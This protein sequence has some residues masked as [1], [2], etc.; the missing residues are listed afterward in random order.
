MTAQEEEVQGALSEG[1]E[2]LDLYTPVRIEKKPDGSV[3]ALWVSRNMVGKVSFERA[4]DVSIGA[5]DERVECD[6]IVVAV[7]Q[8]IETF[9]M[10][11]EG[12]PIQRGVIQTDH[13]SAVSNAPEVFAGGDCVT[14]PAPSAPSPRARSRRTTS[15]FSS[16]STTRSARIW[17][18]RTPCC[19]TSSSAAAPTCA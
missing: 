8:G 10:E 5:P 11:D 3:A 1:A 2:M 7:G 4:A 9:F 6:V 14:G 19:A 16:A 12:I 13:W 18:C 15:T 17:T